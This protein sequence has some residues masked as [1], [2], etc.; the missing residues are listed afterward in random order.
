[1][2]VHHILISLKSIMLLFV[3]WFIDTIVYGL[4]SL[5]IINPTVKEF[6]AETKDII[7][8]I[9][10]LLILI[11]TVVKIKNASSSVKNN[12]EK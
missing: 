4:A 8:W 3:V 11:L 1:M 10:S 5:V 12:D 6:F 7:A 9:T 2:T